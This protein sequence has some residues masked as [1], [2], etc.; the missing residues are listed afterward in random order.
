M[1]KMTKIQYGLELRLPLN[2]VFVNM[3]HLKRLKIIPYTKQTQQQVEVMGNRRPIDLREGVGFD[4]YD[5]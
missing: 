2:L 3:Q 1:N 4:V 5:L